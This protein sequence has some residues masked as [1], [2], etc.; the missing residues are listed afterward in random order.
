MVGSDIVW[1]Y[2]FCR[3]QAPNTSEAQRR[4][5]FEKG[6]Y[7]GEGP[8]KTM[9]KVGAVAAGLVGMLAFLAK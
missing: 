2:K 7:A 4:F 8:V 5:R 6:T 9:Y 3:D 1:L